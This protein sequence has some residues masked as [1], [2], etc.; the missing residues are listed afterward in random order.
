[1]PHIAASQCLRI[2]LERSEY[3]WDPRGKELR[4]QNQSYNFSSF[5]VVNESTG[6]VEICVPDTYA[7]SVVR[8]LSLS[9]K[10]GIPV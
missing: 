6:R 5:E 10:P 7:K 8:D 3:E 4:F 1:M 2:E 9:S